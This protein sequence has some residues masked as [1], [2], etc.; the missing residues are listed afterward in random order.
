MDTQWDYSFH[1]NGPIAEEHGIGY[2]EKRRK[3]TDQWDYSFH[4][5]GP[6]TEEYGTGYQKNKRVRTTNRITVSGDFLCRGF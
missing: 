1:V 6:I 5:N 4:V 2:Q 3:W